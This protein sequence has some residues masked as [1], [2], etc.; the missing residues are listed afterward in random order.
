MGSVQK[1]N[2]LAGELG[3]ARDNNGV[4][5]RWREELREGETCRWLLVG[6][7]LRWVAALAG[8]RKE[9]VRDFEWEEF[10]LRQ[11]EVWILYNKIGML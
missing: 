2:G 3:A 5:G 1:K 4:Q 10:K 11:R 9:Y 7:A 8:M 6:K